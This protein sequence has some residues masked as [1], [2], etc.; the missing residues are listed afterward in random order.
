VLD[1]AGELA[2][3]GAALID[4]ILGGGQLMHNRRGGRWRLLGIGPGQR[5]GLTGQ[6]PAQRCA[7]T[8]VELTEAAAGRVGPLPQGEDLLFQHFAGAK[9]A[10]QFGHLTG[11][12]RRSPRT[13]NRYHPR[14]GVHPL[15]RFRPDRT[16]HRPACAW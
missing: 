9:S 14:P 7:G 11:P 4:Q 3:D 10:S 12:F 13:Q 16:G 1:P 8:P 6:Q 15:C 5:G 2:P